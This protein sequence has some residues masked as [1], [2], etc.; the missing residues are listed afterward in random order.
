MKANIL[1]EG[2][3]GTGKTTVL[4]TLVPH[5][6]HV[7]VLTTEPGIEHAFGPKGKY[8]IPPEK[9][10][11]HYLPIA[12]PSWDILKR[13]ATLINT[14]SYE[15]LTKTSGEKQE[16][17]QFYNLLASCA[18]FIDDRTGKNFGAV[19]SWGEDI[20][21]AM[22][23]L[24]GISIMA[25]QLVVGSKP[26]KSQP[27]WQVA[28][29]LVHGLLQKLVGDTK[30]TFVLI[31]HV[32]RELNEVTGATNVTVSTLGRKLAPKLPP[33]FD[34]VIRAMRVGKNF[35]WSTADPQSDLKARSLPIED[36][37]QPDFGMIFK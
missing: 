6:S 7:R 1:I 25:M 30:C 4:R 21:F 15:A 2:P 18:E 8:P 20:A 28:Q 17:K 35:S 36:N 27:D 24:T 19:D 10:A 33:M 26:V 13:N 22:D 14:V 23:G 9:M 16:Y 31:S 32:E 5:F 12:R 11:W 3:T 37:I 34:E 29:D